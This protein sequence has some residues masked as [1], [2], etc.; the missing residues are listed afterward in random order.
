MGAVRLGWWAHRE[1]EVEELGHLVVRCR[2]VA[3]FLQPHPLAVL[4][5]HRKV[6]LAHLQNIADT[7]LV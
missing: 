2:P 1:E 4:V 3:A 7:R 5:A 6:Q